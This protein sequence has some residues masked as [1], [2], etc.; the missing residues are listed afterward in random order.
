[1][2][3]P[4]LISS[5]LSLLYPLTNTTDKLDAVGVFRKRK[6][7]RSEVEDEDEEEELSLLEYLRR[8]EKSSSGKKKKR[9]SG[10]AI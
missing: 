9:V 8:R 6:R 10:P 2:H 4:A 7:L 1:M 5:S 3:F